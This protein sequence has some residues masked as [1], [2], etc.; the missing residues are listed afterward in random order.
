MTEGRD[1]FEVVQSAR[2]ADCGFDATTLADDAIAAELR[3][4]AHEWT[5]LLTGT[6]A[7]P[8]RRRPASTVWSA[9]EY[10]AHVR[11]T[12]AVFDARI[13]LALVEHEPELGWW[14]HEAAVIT[15]RY[16]SQEPATVSRSI[17]ANAAT[18]ATR[19]DAMRDDEWARVATRRG[20]ERFTVGGL[21]RFALHEAQHHLVDARASIVSV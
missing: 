12:I 2:C 15:D 4:V 13:G 7:A 10:G 8:L 17:V 18:L 9:L 20:T 5:T 3:R 1:W 21:G 6:T 11:D 16:N 14:D 19:L